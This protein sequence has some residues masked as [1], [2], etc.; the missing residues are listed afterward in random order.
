MTLKSEQ[1]PSH[2][3]F[4][5]LPDQTTPAHGHCPSSDFHQILSLLL[6]Q[7]NTLSAPSFIIPRA[8]LLKYLLIMIAPCST[9][10][11]VSLCES[12][13]SR[14]P[15]TL[16]THLCPSKRP[17]KQILVSL[18]SL[19]V[20]FLPYSCFL[21]FTCSCNHLPCDILDLEYLL[22]TLDILVFVNIEQLCS[23]LN[24]ICYSPVTTQVA[25]CS[26]C[27]QT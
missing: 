8:I 16:Q 18:E 24:I 26:T 14:F 1:P 23:L 17:I 25:F 9:T 27:V 15:F 12:L 13:P 11:S 6:S 4:F 10:L 22:L 19:G 7:K 2:H 3:I 21:L 5:P 20:W